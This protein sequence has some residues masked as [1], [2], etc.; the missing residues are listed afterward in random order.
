MELSGLPG[1]RSLYSGRSVG[2]RATSVIDYP[3]VPGDA[4][5]DFLPSVACRTPILSVLDD[6]LLTAILAL[7]LFQPLR[8]V[9]FLPRRCA[10]IGSTAARNRVCH[11]DLT[12]L[13]RHV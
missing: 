6:V 8:L 1:A 9:R 10:S 12:M 7:D 13:I 2:T 3:F 4:A 5:Y 11:D